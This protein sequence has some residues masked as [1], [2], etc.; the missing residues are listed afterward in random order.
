MTDKH[1]TTEDKILLAAI[2]A[3]KEEVAKYMK[4]YEFQ[5]KLETKLHATAREEVDRNLKSAEFQNKLASNLDSKLIGMVGR[6]EAKATKW[7][8]LAAGVVFL[9]FFIL[10]SYQYVQTREKQ[11][12]IYEQYIKAS[13]LIDSIKD[14]TVKLQEDV[15]TPKK[16]AQAI[17]TEM[18]GLLSSAKNDVNQAKSELNTVKGELGA[19]K[20][21]YE[22]RLKSLE[23]AE[24][25]I[26]RIRSEIEE[27]IKRSIEQVSTS[28]GERLDQLQ[29]KIRALANRPST[30]ET[31]PITPGKLDVT[32]NK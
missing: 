7:A 27:S 12:D 30:P 31:M 29:E 15:V 16:N 23:T 18:T 9:I 19:T 4:G 28:Q 6:A 22:S 14:T 2:D 5:R 1:P 20:K 25:E 17:V 32:P 8:G 10:M 24:T 26:K 13:E 21:L 3:A 11:A